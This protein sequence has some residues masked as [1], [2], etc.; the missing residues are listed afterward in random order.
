MSDKKG[1][2]APA[3]ESQAAK[4]VK[5]VRT[6]RNPE[7]VPG[8]RKRS[9][10]VMRAIKAAYK[11]KKGPKPVIEKKQKPRHEPRWYPVESARKLKYSRKHNHKPAKLRASITP[12]TVLIVLAGRFKGKRVVFLKQLPSGLL[13]VT[14]PYEINGV[15]L[16]RLNQAYVIATC[17]K[18]DVSGADVK[19][20]DDG[21]FARAAKPKADKK[22]AT[23]FFQ[24]QKTKT[25][26][27][28]TRKSEQK[29]VDGA[30]V[31]KITAVANL[32][33]YLNAHFTLTNGMHPHAIKF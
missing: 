24:T 2:P 22:D 29:R 12:G 13:L 33:S 16:R 28:D 19:A 10:Y 5:K 21:F 3:K 8:I 14:G 23:E 30:L 9:K 6:S 26:L 7:L 4:A 31:P 20:I 25:P 32:M 17:T 11:V 27:S 1:A 15:P 18:V